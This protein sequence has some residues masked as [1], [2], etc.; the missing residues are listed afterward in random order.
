MKV[1]PPCGEGEELA[2]TSSRRGTG[3]SFDPLR[4]LKSWPPAFAGVTVFGV[5]FPNLALLP[6][7]EG[8]GD[9]VWRMC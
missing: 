8:Y 1:P 9:R 3:T 5:E 2:L 7:G 6:L 4:I